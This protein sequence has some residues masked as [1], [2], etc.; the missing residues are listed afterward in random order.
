MVI[1]Y[2]IRECTG[3]LPR[4]RLEEVLA[5]LPFNAEVYG[6]EENWDS[7][8]PSRREP[9]VVD[10][11]A[12]LIA[13][14]PSEGMRLIDAN[15]GGKYSKAFTLSRLMDECTGGGSC[16]SFSFNTRDLELPYSHQ[17]VVE[18]YKEHKKHLT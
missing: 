4:E 5:R 16:S 10:H 1:K 6:A 7:N 11:A 2:A 3:I 13:L 8:I 14:M 9:L 12:S 18:I 15:F 17:M